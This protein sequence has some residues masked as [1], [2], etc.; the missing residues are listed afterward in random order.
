MVYSG[1]NWN[2]ESLDVNVKEFRAIQK[3]PFPEWN[4]RYAVWGVVSQSVYQFYEVM[5]KFMP[6]A[7]L[8][9]GIDIA[10]EGLY[11][12]RNIIKP[13]DIYNL[14]ED[15]IIILTDPSVQESVKRM[16]MELER[17]FVLLNGADAEYYNF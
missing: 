10:A 4:F 15:V 2:F 6:N 1:V 3:I 11:C 12:G 14:P 9:A 13:K 7:K 17:S 8:T 16:L 5:K